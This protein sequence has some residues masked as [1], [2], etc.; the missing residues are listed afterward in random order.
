MNQL[1]FLSEAPPANPSRSLDL[2]QAWLTRV[3]TSCSG[4]VRL[5]T[6]FAPAGSFGK[7]SPESCHQTV[8]G[9]LAPSSGCWQSSGMGSPTEFLTLNISDWPSAAAVCSL[10]DILETGDVP[11]RYFL[12]AKACRGILRRA[13]KRGKALPRALQA[14]LQIRSVQSETADGAET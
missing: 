9:I 5:L 10:S 14:A 1:T 3:A 4:L 2:E 8:D 7:M 6:D 12:S 11:Q 13:E